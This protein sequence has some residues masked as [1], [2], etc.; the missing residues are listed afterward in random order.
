MSS[1]FEEQL[2]ELLNQYCQENGSNTPDFI[3]AEFIK[4]SLNTFNEMVNARDAWYG[5]QATAMYNL[6]DV[7]AIEEEDLLVY[8]DEIERKIT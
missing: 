3:L 7:A 4:K 8:F 1:T 2:T 6:D 5:H